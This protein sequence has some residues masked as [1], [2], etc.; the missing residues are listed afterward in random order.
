[1]RFS[2][3][4]LFIVVT[5]AA[6][7]GLQGRMQASSRT[8]FAA[9]STLIDINTATP[10][11][12]QSLPGMGPAYVHRVIAGRPYTAKNQLATRGV[13]PQSEYGRIA[14]YIVAKHPAQ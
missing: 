6:F 1:M 9:R 2:R 5:V 14:P 13:L 7:A 8:F 4:L 12:L 11:Q 10:A 3:G